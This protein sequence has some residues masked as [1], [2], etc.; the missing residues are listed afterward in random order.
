MQ[1]LWAFRCNPSRA[2]QR[3]AAALCMLR[4]HNAA[5]VPRVGHDFAS[6]NR[7]VF[8]PCAALRA[9]HRSISSA[10]QRLTKAVKQK[11]PTAYILLSIQKFQGILK[12]KCMEESRPRGC[13]FLENSGAACP[14]YR[15]K[16]G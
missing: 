6:Q 3:V 7:G 1:I 15:K 8:R 12:N 2:H 5:P 14:V 11:R 4:I 16:S 9:A 10:A 13:S